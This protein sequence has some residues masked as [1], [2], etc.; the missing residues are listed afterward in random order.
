VGWCLEANRDLDLAAALD[1]HAFDDP[2]GEL[3]AALVALG[4]VHRLITP[5]LFNVSALVMHL[6]F[7]QI[8]LDRGFTA[9]VTIAELARVEDA[10]ADAAASLARA[11]P[12]R[13]DGALVLDELR[14]A[15]AL[16]TVLCHDG[17][18][19]LAGD[20]WLS[21][22]P[23]ARRA[24]LAVELAPV[25]DAHRA[26]WLARNRSGGLDDSCAWLEHLRRCYVTGRTE[27]HWGGW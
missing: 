6:Y 2:V 11:R 23:D 14:N 27:P 10:L 15:I 3:G 25:V 4:D 13:A 12:R 17:R 1:A 7:P 5:Q 19:R 8:Q 20:G 22:V 21:S 26:L 18:A 24:A 16:V 9:G